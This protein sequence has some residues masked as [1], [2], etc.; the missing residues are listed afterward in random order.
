MCH[1]KP[2]ELFVGNRVT[3]HPT[4]RSRELFAHTA[5][6]KG[7]YKHT[8]GDRKSPPEKTNKPTNK[9]NQKT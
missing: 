1:R 5:A 3:S 7:V 8:K 6:M 9:T 2:T 4:S